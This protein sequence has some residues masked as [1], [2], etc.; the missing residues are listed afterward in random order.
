MLNYVSSLANQVWNE[1][2]SKL[3]EQQDLLLSGDGRCDSPGHRGKFIIH[4][5]HSF[6]P[7][8]IKLLLLLLLYKIFIQVHTTSAHT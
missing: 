7:Y 5:I 4:L 6:N 3:S 8:F 1:E 2:Q